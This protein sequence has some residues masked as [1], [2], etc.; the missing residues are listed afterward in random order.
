MTPPRARAAYSMESLFGPTR[1]PRR[2]AFTPGERRRAADEY[3][4]GVPLWRIAHDLN[5]GENAVRR[6]LDDEGLLHPV[7]ATP[8]PPRY[9]LRADAFTADSPESHYWAGFL[10]A[11]GSIWHTPGRSGT[12][13]VALQAQDAPHLEALALF[14][15]TDRA[16]YRHPHQESVALHL[17][18]EGLAAGL[19]ARGL[20][21]R[22][23]GRAPDQVLRASRDFWRGVLDAD[24]SILLSRRRPIVTLCAHPPSMAAFTDYARGHCQRAKLQAHA[25]GGIHVVTLGGA[26]A[27]R[28]LAA[29]YQPGDVALPRKAAR[30]AVIAQHLQGHNLPPGT[31]FG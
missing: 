26:E 14:L 12:V 16:L 30:A 5:T 22:K 9:R 17:S 11:D 15:G 28:L 23:P 29:L 27:G 18:S 8:R 24:G 20:A 7:P 31:S 4:R 2:G 1:K 10:S 21:G 3:R 19:A 6:V 13:N 25:R